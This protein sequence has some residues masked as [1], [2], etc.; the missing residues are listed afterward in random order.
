MATYANAV[1]S[2]VNLGS[3]VQTRWFLLLIN[4]LAI[5]VIYNDV[6]RAGQASEQNIEGLNIQ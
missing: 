6:T 5:A 2:T 1:T 3:V 4:N